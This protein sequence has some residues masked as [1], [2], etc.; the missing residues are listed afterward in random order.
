MVKGQIEFF[1]LISTTGVKLSTKLQCL[2]IFLEKLKLRI[3]YIHTHVFIYKPTC[4]KIKEIGWRNVQI[5]ANQSHK[6]QF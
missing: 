5:R 4:L 6:S 1:V 3:F 2:N